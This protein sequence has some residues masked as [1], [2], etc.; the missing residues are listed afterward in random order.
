MQLK[1]SYLHVNYNASKLLKQALAS[2]IDAASFT[3][4]EIIVVDDVSTEDSVE[5]IKI[6]FPSVQLIQ[7]VETLWSE[8][9][10]NKAVNSAIE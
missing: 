8:A 10:N 9:S 1:V 5:M 2:E 7:N 6:K 3:T 4:F